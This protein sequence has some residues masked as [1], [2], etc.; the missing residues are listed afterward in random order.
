[1]KIRY[2]PALS[3]CFAIFLSALPLLIY[4]VPVDTVYV[5]AFTFGS[6][7]DSTFVFPPAGEYR[8]VLMYYTLKCNPAQSPNCGRWDYLTYTYL[9][10]HTGITDS[11][12]SKIDSMY[13]P[14]K[15][16]YVKDT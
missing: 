9:Y 12:V 11:S 14:V 3:F 8:K 4:A 10:Q 1:M 7:Q 15:K 6:K 16:K 5:Q 13:D 2:I